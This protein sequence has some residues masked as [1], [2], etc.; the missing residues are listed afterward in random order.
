MLSARIKGAGD[1]HF[2]EH[3]KASIRFGYRCFD[4]ILGERSVGNACR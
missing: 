2:Y 1:E 4:R 3:H